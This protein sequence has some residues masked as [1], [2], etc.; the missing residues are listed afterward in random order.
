MDDH[1]VSVIRTTNYDRIDIRKALS[2]KDGKMI[3]RNSYK[4]SRTEECLRRV[5]EDQ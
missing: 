4:R 5:S 2:V 1:G 3:W